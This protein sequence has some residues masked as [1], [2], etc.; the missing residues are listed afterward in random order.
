MVGTDVF[1]IVSASQQATFSPL[2]ANYSGGAAAGLKLVPGDGTSQTYGPDLYLSTTPLIGN[3]PGDISARVGANLNTAGLLLKCRDMQ[4]GLQTRRAA[5]LKTGEWA[6]TTLNIGSYDT[7]DVFT[8]GFGLTW[9]TVNAAFDAP[10]LT[11]GLKISNGPYGP[12]TKVLTEGSETAIAYV[13]LNASEM[14]GGVIDFT[15]QVTDNTDFQVQAGRVSFSC[16]RKSTTFTSQIIESYQLESSA[17]S[18]GTLT[19]VWTITGDSGNNRISI[20]VNANSSLTA[21]TGY[22]LLTYWITEMTGKTITPQ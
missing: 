2:Y 4:T 21:T 1:T 3:Q 11:S 15:I 8:K 14:T 6:I 7:S 18:T 9:D 16:V 10:V 20:L 17:N 5:L 13:S 22:P 12:N 19:D